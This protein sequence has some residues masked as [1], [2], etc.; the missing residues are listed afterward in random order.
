M[1]SYASVFISATALTLKMDRWFFKLVCPRTDLRK[2]KVT[3]TCLLK[4]CYCPFKTS[5]S[6]ITSGL[7]GNQNIRVSAKRYTECFRNVFYFTSLW[8][9]FTKSKCS[10]WILKYWVLVWDKYELSIILYRARQATL[11]I[12]KLTYS[13]FLPIDWIAFTLKGLSQN[14][15]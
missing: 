15:N 2:A 7:Y 12:V 9:H 1:H 8:E 4:R 11:L 13:C 6:T 5:G 3:Q 10:Y 14:S